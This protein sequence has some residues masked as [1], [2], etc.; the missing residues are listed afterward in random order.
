MTN[1]ELIAYMLVG[2]AWWAWEHKQAL[3][4]GVG[5]VVVFVWIVGR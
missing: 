5:L 1:R 2:I 4:I 3:L